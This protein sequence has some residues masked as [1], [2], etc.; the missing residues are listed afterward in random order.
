M[1]AKC[2][3]GD[4][5]NVELVECNINPQ[6]GSLTCA[7]HR[8]PAMADTT[9]TGTT[10]TGKSYVEMDVTF[11]DE[12]GEEKVKTMVQ[13]STSNGETERLLSPS[14]AAPASPVHR[15]RNLEKVLVVLMAVLG[16]VIGTFL[17]TL[18]ICS[19]VS[20]AVLSQAAVGIWQVA[21]VCG[22]GVA[23][24]I[25]SVSYISDAHLNPAITLAFA[26]VRYKVFSWK[27]VVPYILAQMFGGIF[28]GGVLYAFKSAAISLYEEE[29]NIVR[30]ENASVITAMMFGEYFP[31]PSLYTHSDPQHL[32]VVS[33]LEALAV[34]M[35]TTFILA[36]VIFALTDESNAS[37]GR[38]NK[39]L[40]P[41]MIGFTVATVISIYGSLTQVGMN[42]AR[43]FGPRIIAACAGWGTVA[44]PG[45][46]RGFWV[47]IVGPMVGALLGAILNGLV[48]SKALKGL[49]R[50]RKDKEQDSNIL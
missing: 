30:G 8:T 34:E 44:I 12:F 42:P 6:T 31:N 3:Y 43:D 22:L 48:I 17:L 37:V 7:R 1:S 28:A 27:R 14:E 29:N 40:A 9:D 18:V 10:D 26:I 24:S 20:T 45:P 2:R 32:E 23:I 16:E 4:E 41:L 46:R 50:W 39:V 35:W 38:E 36:F 33:T 21:V 5:E 47:Y 15:S 19:M 49:K 13:K 25:Y 11:V